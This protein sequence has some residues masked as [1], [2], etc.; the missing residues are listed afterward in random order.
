MKK[1]V[2]AMLACVM[3]FVFVFQGAASAEKM[4][5]DFTGFTEEQLAPYFDFDLER[6]RANIALRNPNAK[7]IP[8]CAKTGEG[9]EEWADWLRAQVKAWKA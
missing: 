7:V 8:I 1:T 4:P 5:E 9:M 3:T 6:C 2:S